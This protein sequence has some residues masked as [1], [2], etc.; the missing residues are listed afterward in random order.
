MALQLKLYNFLHHTIRHADQKDGRQFVE[1]YLAGPQAWWEATHDKIEAVKDL[2]SVVDCPDVYLK[3]LKWIVGW[4]SELDGVTSGLTYLQLRRLISVSASLWKERGPEDTIKDILRLLTGQRVRVWNWFD[5]RILVGEVEMGE[6]LSGFDPWLIDDPYTFQV[7]IV[8]DGALNRALVRQLVNLMRACG[9]TIDVSYLTFLDLFEVDYDAGQWARDGAG[10]G[11]IPVANGQL[12]LDDTGVI[13]IAEVSLTGATAWDEYCVTA[14]LQASIS[15][16]GGP[17]LQFYRAD[18]LNYYLVGLDI[19]SNKVELY[20]FVS[21]APTLLSSVDRVLHN[22]LWY[23]LRV[24]VVDEASTNR[25]KIY[26]DADE[27]TDVTDSTYAQGSVA[28]GHQAGDDLIC[29]EIEIFSVPMDTDE[30]T[31]NYSE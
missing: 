17:G 27:I 14:R 13:E 8:D 26:L 2:W 28:L 20:K 19:A 31:P 22:D 1:R 6:D 30:I 25:I 4:T 5:W 29:S 18:N 21:G 15:A 3:Y 9:E 10:S 7:R 12:H 16:T 11:D 24:V 23:V